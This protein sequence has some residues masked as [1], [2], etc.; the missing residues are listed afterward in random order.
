MLNDCVGTLVK[1]FLSCRPCN[2]L[3]SLQI[4]I[5]F[6]AGFGSALVLGTV[7]GALADRTGRRLNCLAFAVIYATSCILTHSES[8]ELLLVGRI[9]G[10]I[11]GSI[12]NTAFESWMVSEHNSRGFAGAWLGQTFSLAVFGSGV[13]A[14]AAGLVATP[15][16]SIFGVNAPFD[17]SA[18][19]LAIGGLVILSRW[20]ENYG[21]TSEG[22]AAGGVGESFARAWAVLRSN[23][24]VAMVG[25]TQT[26]FEAAM[27]IFVFFWTPTLEA[28]L[29]AYER[30]GNMH[31]EHGVVDSSG[32][33]NLPH[34]LVFACYM[35][36]VMI[37]SKLF[38]SVAR[39]H[40]AETWGFII[41]AVASASLLVPVV[42]SN[43]WIQL[44]SLCT[45][46]LCCG[47]YFPLISVLRSKYIP[48]EVRSTLMNMFRIGL[49][50][51]VLTVLGHAESF[52]EAQSFLLCSALLGGAVLPQLNLRE[53]FT[54][55]VAGVTDDGS[56][57]KGSK[58]TARKASADGDDDDSSLR[59]ERG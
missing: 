42:V 8:F 17:V 4:G 56:S 40:A 38:E 48:E 26:L 39:S 44:F 9:L 50:I 3:I 31:I 2:S 37:G 59:S 14:I 12:L 27:Y 52:G 28:S 25:I 15:L 11:S 55:P 36:S 51:I 13:A 46:E 49:N 47:C 34:G 10:G 5:L 57:G 6:V 24:M 16:V 19:C 30:A 53:G 18:V 45:F 20:N 58:G 21:E 22:T 54:A 32:G 43:H 33:S 41:F 7:V 29:A 35:V 1:R 23:S